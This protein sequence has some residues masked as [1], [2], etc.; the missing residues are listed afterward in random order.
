MTD[1]KCHYCEHV[2]SHFKVGGTWSM[3]HELHTITDCKVKGIASVSGSS[4]FADELNARFETRGMAKA[5]YSLR[6]G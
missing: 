6:G 3:Q 4:A 1:G 5:N 2:E